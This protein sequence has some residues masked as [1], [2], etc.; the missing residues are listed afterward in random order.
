MVVIVVLPE[1]RAVELI[2]SNYSRF[3]LVVKPK[4]EQR[5]RKR[6]R[7]RKQVVENVP[8]FDNNIFPLFIHEVFVFMKLVSLQLLVKD[9]RERMSRF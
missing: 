8:S 1:C 4:R 2:L 5:K 3:V 7:E 6:I 9:Q